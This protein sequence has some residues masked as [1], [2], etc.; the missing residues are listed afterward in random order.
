MHR[1]F[2]GLPSAPIPGSL[3]RS[4]PKLM[5]QALE[6]VLGVSESEGRAI[7]NL[8][9]LPDGRDPTTVKRSLVPRQPK[10]A[11]GSTLV[12]CHSRHGSNG[13]VSMQLSC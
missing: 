8:A 13:S 1:C 11:G 10:P 12:L 9:P 6:V 3:I 4:P 2:S 7:A 5:L